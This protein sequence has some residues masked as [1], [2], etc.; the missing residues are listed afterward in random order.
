MLSLKTLGSLSLSLPL[1]AGHAAAQSQSE[2]ATTITVF[3]PFAPA[4]LIYGSVIE[5]E[6]D[7]TTMAI[8]CG[9][10]HDPD[11]DDGCH[12]PTDPAPTMVFGPNTVAMSA[13]F[14]DPGPSS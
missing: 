11:E 6:S 2:E 5:A 8:D 14:E 1:L 13:E 10:D 7:A 12:I 3:Y 9:P 4:T